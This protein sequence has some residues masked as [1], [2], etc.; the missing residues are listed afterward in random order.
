MCLFAGFQMR[1]FVQ[2]DFGLI[3]QT[4]IPNECNFTIP[5]TLLADP[6]KGV[7]LLIE[8]NGCH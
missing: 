4:G 2:Q 3:N 5:D 6:R 8:F 1:Q 7:K